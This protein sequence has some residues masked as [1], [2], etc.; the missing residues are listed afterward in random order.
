MG[1]VHIKVIFGCNLC[2]S[3]VFSAH[4]GGPCGAESNSHFEF[5][6]PSFFFQNLL[7]CVAA[8]EYVRLIKASNELFNWKFVPGVDLSFG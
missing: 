7:L 1:L 4:V 8:V 6:L 5:D 2:V 3:E